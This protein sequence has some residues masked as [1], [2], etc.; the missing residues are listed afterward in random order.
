MDD[1]EM[2][3]KV[4]GGLACLL[5]QRSEFKPTS[6]SEPRRPIFLEAGNA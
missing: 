5:Q 3:R 6:K 4:F 2:L 1:G